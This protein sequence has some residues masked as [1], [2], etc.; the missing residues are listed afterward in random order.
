MSGQSG[1]AR[2][3][4]PAGGRRRVL[5]GLLTACG[6]GVGGCLESAMSYAPD[7]R[8]LALAVREPLS[9]SQDKALLRGGCSYRVM[10]LTGRDTLRTV[11]TSTTHMLSA[12]AYSPDGKRLCYL[13]VPLPTGA[14]ARQR[15]AQRRERIEKL[16]A[17]ARD[18]SDA[19]ALQMTDPRG[20]VD[21]N[22]DPAV[23]MEDKT[24]PGAA[25][26]AILL[27]DRVVSPTV[28]AELV[29]RRAAGGEVVSTLR[30]RLP[31][32]GD[33]A[34]YYSVRPSYGPR[35]K[36]VYLATGHLLLRVHP[37]LS[38][39]DIVAAPARAAAVSPDGEAVAAVG[40][41]SLGLIAADGER[42][43]Y[44]RWQQD[45]SLRTVAWRDAN[46]LGALRTRPRPGGDGN[47]VRE[48]VLL[49]TD[50]RVR[51]VHELGDLP[52]GAALQDGELAFSPDGRH[53][54]ANYATALW[55]FD[56]DGKVV[57]EVRQPKVIYSAPTFRPDGK[58]VA[59]KRLVEVGK[60]RYRLAEVVFFSPAGERLAAKEI[61][62]VKP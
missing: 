30:L 60:D 58:A 1:P 20:E 29:V 6:A 26:G 33:A 28:P 41:D 8:H 2:R 45:S 11:E 49:G 18:A 10:V 15:Q 5:V 57:R 46:T 7:G 22:D 43:A 17:L 38:R 12:P 56:A 19:L 55:F 14:Q 27:H 36:W 62:S 32:V 9:D 37:V 13:R 3:R 35:G 54:V 24:L 23:Q 44:L 52:G 61:P 40:A 39:C 21:A 16:K 50:G 47:D 59:V 4:G 25:R 34:D 48:L 42:A 51:G 53:A 31:L